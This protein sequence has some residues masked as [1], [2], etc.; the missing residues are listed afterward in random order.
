MRQ[1]SAYKANYDKLEAELNLVKSNRASESKKLDASHREIS[2]KIERLE[3]ENANLK[4]KINDLDRLVVEYDDKY[5]SIKAKEQSLESQ[6]KHLEN[7]LDRL[8]EELGEAREQVS[9][10][11]NAT[12]QANSSSEM[13]SQTGMVT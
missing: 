12:G 4:N 5:T 1:I 3:F 7:E 2:E 13:Q 11:N 6:N 8:S 9:R 10:V